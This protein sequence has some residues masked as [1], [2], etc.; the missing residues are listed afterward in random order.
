MHDDWPHMQQFAC[1]AVEEAEWDVPQNDC[2]SC[3]LERQ[4]A[5]IAQKILAC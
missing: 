1:N 3:L 5:Y 4:N 2:A